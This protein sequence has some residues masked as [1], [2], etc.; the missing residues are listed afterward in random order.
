MKHILKNV[1]NLPRIT[2]PHKINL[3]NRNLREKS[4][5]YEKMFKKEKSWYTD[6]YVI[7]RNKNNLF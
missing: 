3:L 4:P 5:Y 2:S 6:K 7:Q 1:I